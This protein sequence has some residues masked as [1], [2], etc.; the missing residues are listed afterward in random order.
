[1]DINAYKLINEKLFPHNSLTNGDS[2]YALKH[3][4]IIDACK[5]STPIH[6]GRYQQTYITF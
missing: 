2:S 3:Y 6:F 1:M 5:S 4:V